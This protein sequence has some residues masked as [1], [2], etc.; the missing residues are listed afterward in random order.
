MI[1][2]DMFYRR[3]G[4]RL[5]QHL[6]TPVI[7][8]LDKFEFPRNSLL[9]YLTLDGV[10]SGPA[11]DD[12][13]FRLITKQILMDHV[14]ELSDSKGTPRKVNLSVL[15]YVKEYHTR[16]RRFRYVKDVNSITRDEMTLLV[17]NFDFIPKLYRYVRSTFSEYYKWWNI[18][19]TLWNTVNVSASSSSRQQYIFTDLPK[20]LPSVTSLN[21][22]SKITNSTLIKVFPSSES[23]F[24]LELWKWLSVDSRDSGVMAGL[25]KNNLSKINIVFKESGSWLM[26]N[27]GVL[28]S[29]RYDQDN[30]N[31]ESKAQ[32]VK[33][34]PAQ[35]QKRLLFTL[36]SLMAV[37]TSP[38]DP[39]QETEV[40]EKKA[41]DTPQEV[42]Q[43]EESRL[44]K[45]DRFL[46]K[47]ESN[48]EDLEKIE[49][50][51]IV[52]LQPNI[53]KAQTQS[54]IKDFHTEV[55]NEGSVIAICDK[56]AEDGLLTAAVYKNL[57]TSA[58][59]YKKILAPDGKS[60]LEEFIK[61]SP[62]D[63][64]ISASKAI[65]DIKTVIDK[66]MLKSSLLNFDQDYINKVL[67]KDIASMV[68]NVQKGG[69]IL[70]NYTVEKQQDMLGNYENHIIRVR[71][72]EGV[73]STLRFKLPSVDEDGLIKY[74]GTKYKLRKQ[75]GDLPIRKI[76][77]GTVALTSYYG[78]T[79][80]SRNTKKVND[81]ATW[82]TNRVMEKGLDNSSVDVTDI[83]TSNVF[84]NQFTGPRTYSI[85][86]M[87]FKSLSAKGYTF[88]FDHFKRAAL[89]GQDV[90][91][92]LE[93]DGSVVVATNGK[94]S[95][96]TMDANDILYT[97]E[98]DNLRLEGSVEEFFK[99]DAASA[100]IEFSEIKIFGVF[101]PVCFFLAYQLGFD[102]LLEM[103]KVSPRKVPA[104]ERVGLDVDE[105]AIVFNDVTYVFSK[106]DKLATMILAGFLQ[107]DKTL[108][109]Y[110]AQSL[111]NPNVYLN[112]L[113]ASG[114]SA[115]YLREIDLLN[116]LFI[117]PITK[118]LLVEMK[119]PT[120][121]RGLLVRSSELL[122]LDKH[123]D[124]MDMKYMRIK[125]YERLAGAVY[126]ELIQSI[127]GHGARSGKS[128]R[129][130]EMHP[131]AV[132]KRVVQDPSMSLI[133]DINPIQN[134]K[135]VEA[136]TFSG[137]GG[138]NAR[139][140]VR[141]SREYHKNDMGVIS[142]STVDSGNVA[143]ITYMSADPQFKSLRGTT[144]PFEGSD[145]D[146]TALLSTSAL[147][148]PGASNDDPKR[149]NYISVQHSHGIA[150]AG[151]RQSAVR[152]G[153]EQ[154]LAHRTT[155]LF[156]L[157]AKQD[158]Q[159][160]SKNATGIQ[161]RYADG[162][163][164]GY[165]IGRR[166]GNAAGLVI[167]HNVTCD[168]NIGDKFKEGDIISYNTGFFE[169]DLLNPKQVIWKVG[170]T[171]K[172]VLYE[173]SQTLEDA[174]SI[175][176]AL[177]EK[178]MTKLTKVKTVVVKFDQ[179]VK[180][181]I[182]VNDFVEPESILCTIEDAVTSN[183][184]LFDDESLN[185][186]RLLSN[187]TPT[188][189]TKGIVEKIEV[190]YHGDKEDMSETLRSISTQ[191][192]KDLTA[193]NKSVGGSS[194]TGSVDGDLRVDGEPLALD[195]VAIR[196][197]ITSD[198]AASVGDKGVFCNQLKTVFS[199]V[200][201]GEIRT[202]RGEIIDA[203]FGQKSIQDRIVLSPALIGTTNTLLDV[204][205]K[206]AAKLYKKGN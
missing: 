60:T 39:D 20:I 150:C 169:R 129:P 159:I 141:S 43:D 193:R 173:S 142:E 85:L 32:K 21:N 137:T 44:E 27:L 155:D 61:I 53:V 18:Q 77:P 38:V 14:L 131:Y 156:A 94:G 148:S 2:Q 170:I 107:Y 167:P 92:K 88:N 8:T 120:T 139:S 98:G 83:A 178:L 87:T 25:D 205:G 140:M 135:E 30:E 81:Y 153:Y 149:V 50:K 146:T 51:S 163:V 113:E 190:F 158:G 7:S 31:P 172:T 101:I 1:T 28:E 138:R 132:W 112:I 165:E 110:P 79:F 35:L 41:L 80:V 46:E 24:I 63:L 127:R 78:K 195:S 10:R 186:L 13:F 147:L 67:A 12:Y 89:F 19:K 23:L 68:V 181:L 151:Y 176:K 73:A 95:F 200:L 42:E 100:P 124:Q 15:P 82:L 123:P 76:S 192:D 197:Y 22:Y 128:T 164:K 75:R 3:H 125:G 45:A 40:E 206:K 104:G 116:N 36:M 59:N 34:A 189:K 157:T 65:P 64:T 105:Y 182:K 5:P 180:G 9:N 175:S 188:A 162:T 17:L 62:E 103:L 160:I 152:T 122:L 171:A 58:G 199:E 71:P 72:V 144:K 183:S 4:V 91:D 154:I 184:Q 74:N 52:E 106:D 97:A 56:L 114:L 57:T 102:N 187:Q 37:R 119:E 86:A 49:E 194:L 84:D 185:T 166:F 11:S 143:V 16:N 115:R 108:R 6:M 117:D 109:K 174:S 203:V 55:S 136:I 47:L 121:F 66:S 198:V 33:I 90:L 111:N 118:D 161:I 133:S 179:S 96:L 70:S 99:I 69:V 177:S 26:I 48:L 126:S 202:E 201:A 54:V 204:I 93:V 130:L 29:W 196:F 191:F 145:I 168:L 134:L